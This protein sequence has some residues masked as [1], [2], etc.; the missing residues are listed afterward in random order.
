MFWNKQKNKT[1]TK[2][3]VALSGVLDA[4]W[5]AASGQRLV[6]AGFRQNPVS[7]RCIRLVAETS[8]S[9]PV[10]LACEL[11]E[12]DAARVLQLLERPQPGVSGQSL[13]DAIYGDLQVSGNAF[14]ELVSGADEDV[15]G[16]QRVPVGAVEPL[17]SGDGF[18]IRTASGRRVVRSDA[19]GWSP[20][21]HLRALD[22]SS[23]TLAMSP[24]QAASRAVEIHNAGSNW[25][26]ALIDNAARPSGALIYG[27][28]GAHMTPDQFSR[29]KDQLESAHM[30]AKHAGRPMLLEGG[31]D[32]KPMSLSPTDMDF[33]EARRESAREIALAFGVPPMLLGIPG[34][35]TYANY[36]EAN[37]AFWRLTVLPLV[38]RTVHALEDWFS[39]VTEAPVK[40]KADLDAVP[41]LGPEREALWRRLGDAE[42]LTTEEK[43]EIAGLAKIDPPPAP[44]FQGGEQAERDAPPPLKKGRTEVG[45]RTSQTEAAGDHHAD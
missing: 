43:R 20:L 27:R 39:G 33:I 28:D 2:S 19:N 4:Q 37:L 8:A 17:K 45:I 31:L 5:E 16:L 24:L 3:L 36:R 32:W 42:F 10:R 41:A 26:K 7:Y 9:V 15:A 12:R 22:P 13:L 30:G 34:D 1:E 11:C 14:L 25:T 21:L 23:R 40:L 18:A 44:P 6:E 29:L 35:N 38:Q